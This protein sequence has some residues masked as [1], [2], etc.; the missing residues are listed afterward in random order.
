MKNRTDFIAG[1]VLAIFSILYYMQACSVRVF[2][3]MG[4]SVVNSQTMPKIWAICLL[5]LAVCLI[6]RPFRKNY[7]DDS[8]SGKKSLSL[9][10]TLK[11]N[12]LIIYT[13]GALFLY[14]LALEYVGFIISSAI[15][16]FLQ[17]L[18]LM[19]KKDRNFIKAAILGVVSGAAAFCIFVYWL[20]VLLPVG[21]LFE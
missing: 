13:F 5:L 2:P 18:I 17:T 15:Y 1:I 6:S 11:D 12:T 21:K 7:K 4:K 9:I 14:A 8:S 10:A 3:G 16:I 19:P 20:D